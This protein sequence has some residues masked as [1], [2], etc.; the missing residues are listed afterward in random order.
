MA[1]EKPAK[2]KAK[3]L[4]ELFKQINK[5]FGAGSITQGRDEI[6]PVYAIPTRVPTI[7]LALGCGGLPE[8]RV[9]EVFGMESSG[10]TTTCLQFIA[11][12]QKHFFPHKNR[13]GVAAFI[14]AEHAFDP[15][16]ATNCGVDID[17]LI[18]AQPSSGDEVFD[19]V[20]KICE[21]GLVDLVVV[22]S[23]AALVPRQ[24]LEGEV[25]DNHIGAQARL[26]AKGLRMIVPKATIS[27]TTVIFVNQVRMKIGVMFGCLHGDTMVNFVDDRCLPI[28]RVVQERVEG[29]VWSYDE[30]KRT[31][32]PKAITGWHHN[33]EVDAASDYLSIAIKAPGTRNGRMHLTVTPDHQVLTRDGWWAAKELAVG[34][35][36]LTK[37]ESFVF[38]RGEVNGTLGQFLTG[39]LSGDSHISHNQG[40]LGAALLIQDNVDLEYMRWKIAKLA[41]FMHFAK[42]DY[43]S[44]ERYESNCH[45]ELLQLKSEYPKR[46]P[47][48]L[49]DHFSWLGFAIW[50]MDD[51]VYERGRY[52]LSIKRFAGDF[53]KIEQI[54]RA[55]D[56]L[57]LYHHASK[58]GS[59]TFDKAVSDR[60]A[61][62]IFMFV[63]PC[64]DHKLPFNERGCLGD[65][66]LERPEKWREAYATV[67]EVREASR[68]Q[69][70]SRGKYDLTV[71]GTEC[72][73]A[74]GSENGV[75]VHN[76]P[77][78]TP[79]GLALKFAASLRMQI[80][81]GSPIK[82]RD[83]VIAYRPTIKIIKNKVAAPNTKAEYEICFGKN[84]R[85][86]G[87]D[88][89]ASLMEA[90]AM[91]GLFERS[92]SYYIFSDGTKVN[93]T[94][95][96]TAHIR[97]HPELQ[98][99]L[100][101]KI[102]DTLKNRAPYIPPDGEDGDELGDDILDGLKD[103]D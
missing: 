61:D 37:Q 67:M 65:F 16:W 12:C 85:P 99:Q 28:S 48:I 80:N 100:R 31:F 6:V 90:S 4:G 74:G 86:Y 71:A 42:R 21:S 32:I 88:E 26:M 69:M 45:S 8:G 23:V 92:S 79:G 40:R 75:I 77:E 84:G 14:D 19:I 30:H 43:P 56:S 5:T 20:D 78:T 76:S 3:S 24:E 15:D 83:E 64:M 51:A 38:S 27:K 102:Y 95:A 2:E 35:Q 33:G 93:G 91:L 53:D 9:G 101:N 97:S 58:G 66:E 52:H 54:S 39:V 22:D 63:P 98:E 17:K 55:L 68:R 18:F 29:E 73:S 62:Q 41:P 46:D 11:A 50:I 59:I 10:K 81:K 57:G 1:K 70:R 7:D 103:G 82:D 89:V 87:I 60:I 36:L 25:M 47:M 13:N 96:A 72:Y 94:E 34:D 44:G 49:L